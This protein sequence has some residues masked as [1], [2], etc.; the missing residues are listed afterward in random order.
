ME[1][2]RKSGWGS[3]WYMHHAYKLGGLWWCMVLNGIQHPQQN[4]HDGACAYCTSEDSVPACDVGC[5]MGVGRCGTHVPSTPSTYQPLTNSTYNLH[6]PHTKQQVPSTPLPPKDSVPVPCLPRAWPPPQRVH[7]V[8]T[9]QCLPLTP[10]TSP[11]PTTPNPSKPTH[12]HTHPL[13]SSRRRHANCQNFCNGWVAD[14][15]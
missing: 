14:G 7:R 8:S 3:R 10:P 2:W 4:L 13:H 11:R 15:S 12:A 6:T 1:E 5:G 9:G